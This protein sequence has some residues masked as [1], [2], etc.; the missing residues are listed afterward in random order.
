M[1]L[2]ERKG[3]SRNVGE[4]LGVKKKKKK[5][6]EKRNFQLRKPRKTLSL[7]FPAFL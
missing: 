1:E 2:G 6:K 7:L 4:S 3:K 5:Y